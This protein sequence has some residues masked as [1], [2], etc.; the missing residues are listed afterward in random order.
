M[1]AG[2]AAEN[3]A[4]RHQLALVQGPAQPPPNGAVPPQ[5]QRQAA[6]LPLAVPPPG[7]AV[8]PPPSGIP[9]MPYMQWLPGMPYVGPTPKVRCWPHQGFSFKPYHCEGLQHRGFVHHNHWGT[10][11]AGGCEVMKLWQHVLTMRESGWACS[12]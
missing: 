10:D 12:C 5:Q 8:L 4:L 1:V 3:A 2:L 11:A 7:M 6:P 9:G